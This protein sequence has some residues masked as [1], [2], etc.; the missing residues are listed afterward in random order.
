MLD[1]VPGAQDLLVM[2][3]R[4]RPNARPY[5]HLRPHVAHVNAHRLF[6]G[7]DEHLFAG[8]GAAGAHVATSIIAR[9]AEELGIGLDRVVTTGTSYRAV[10]AT[11]AG[12]LAGAGDIVVAALPVRLATQ[13]R[14]L[15]AQPAQSS[16]VASRRKLFL[17]LVESRGAAASDDEFDTFFVRTAQQATRPT[18]I[19]LLTSPDDFTFPDAL[20]LA[21]QLADHPLVSVANTVED[22]GEHAHVSSSYWRFLDRVLLPRTGRV[23]RPLDCGRDDSAEVPTAREAGPRRCT[24]SPPAAGDR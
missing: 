15:H 13:A 3:S 19:H 6:L 8:H 14:N 12:L 22:Y 1:A 7:A 20:W 11:A 23:D 17:E 21:D 2:F 24:P 4:V 16:K 5:L 9:T 10:M 18:T